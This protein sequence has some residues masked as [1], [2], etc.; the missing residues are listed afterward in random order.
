MGALGSTWDSHFSETSELGTRSFVINT[1]LV[2]SGKRMS[3]RLLEDHFDKVHRHTYS[4]SNIRPLP[5]LATTRLLSAASDGRFLLWGRPHP[6]RFKG[7]R[8]SLLRETLASWLAGC[9]DDTNHRRRSQEEEELI[10][11]AE[12][13]DA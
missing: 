13:L 12:A 6:H 7:N 3:A 1:K 10:L 5:L 2:Q 8:L 11:R 4:H 9:E